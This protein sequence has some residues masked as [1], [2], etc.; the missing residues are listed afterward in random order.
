MLLIL[1]AGGFAADAE[2]V[3]VQAVTTSLRKD[4]ANTAE[5]VTEVKRGDSLTV[6]SREGIWLKV[7]TAKAAEGWIPKVLTSTLAPVGQAQL[8]KDNANL[9]S[10]AK[11]SRR[12]TSDYAVS[13]ATRGLASGERRR[14][15]EES[16]RSNHQAV[17]EIEQIVITPEQLKTFKD[18]G[19]IK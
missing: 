14:P 1:P 6:L 9:D 8:L 15:G 17:E 3:F 2:V 11:S 7:R 19:D 4:R 5:S 10:K 18:D 12:R 16:Y 13:A